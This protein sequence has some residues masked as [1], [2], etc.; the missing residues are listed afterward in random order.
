MNTGSLRIIPYTPKT[1]FYHADGTGK[2]FIV[3]NN[4]F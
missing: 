3:R 4:N 2:R 1:W